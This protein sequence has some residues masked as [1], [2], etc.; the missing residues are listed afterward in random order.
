MRAHSP[1]VAASNPDQTRWGTADGVLRGPARRQAARSGTRPLRVARAT[2]EHSAHRARRGA[3]VVVLKHAPHLAD[4]SAVSVVASV[5]A[6]GWA[7][8]TAGGL[9]AACLAWI[10]GG[11]VRA[12]VRTTA[13]AR[14]DMLLLDELFEG[15]QERVTY[16]PGAGRS[17]DS[18]PAVIIAGATNRGYRFV[19]ATH[20][21]GQTS[22]KFQR[23]HP[24]ARQHL[25]RRV[26][27]T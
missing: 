2:P 27:D 21:D 15:S 13:S 22:M 20:D 16:R 6:V 9:A 17:V 4:K 19:E 18:T 12:S 23:I 26:P 14:R 24:P 25:T 10:I 7:L 11:A 5:T 8:A 1:P 3:C